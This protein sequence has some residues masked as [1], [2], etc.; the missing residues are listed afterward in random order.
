MFEN[1]RELWRFVREKPLGADKQVFYK[2]SS[3]IYSKCNDQIASEPFVSNCTLVVNGH[4]ER[5]FYILY[6][7]NPLISS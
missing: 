6:Q 3:K 5:P 7:Q 2:T 1:I 4:F